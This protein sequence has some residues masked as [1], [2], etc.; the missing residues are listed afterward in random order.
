MVLRRKHLIIC[1]N[2]IMKKLSLRANQRHQ[3]YFSAIFM[4]CEFDVES[5]ASIE[6]VD[7][8][9]QFKSETYSSSRLNPSR[10]VLPTNFTFLHFWE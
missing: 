1:F 9:Y 7:S 5:D 8:K 10:I 4:D 2:E 6:V 3:S